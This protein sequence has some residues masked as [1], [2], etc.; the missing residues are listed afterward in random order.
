MLLTSKEKTSVHIE[1]LPLKCVTRKFLF[2]FF[3][4]SYICV[5]NSLRINPLTAEWALRALIDFTLSN[6]RRFYSSMGNPL[7]GKGLR[8][9]K[10]LKSAFFV[11]NISV[12]ICPQ[13]SPIFLVEIFR[14]ARNVRKHFA[15][16]EKFSGLNAFVA[17]SYPAKNKRKILRA[18]YTSSNLLHFLRVHRLRK[19]AWGVRGRTHEKKF[20]NCDPKAAARRFKRIVW[21]STQVTKVFK[22]IKTTWWLICFFALCNLSVK[23]F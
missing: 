13:K 19:P 5:I 16:S 17:H 11:K 7:T 21:F 20:A 15:F 18:I 22:I 12:L 4:V 3:L 23:E 2:R 6:A 10:T 9:L 14:H 1:N 8:A